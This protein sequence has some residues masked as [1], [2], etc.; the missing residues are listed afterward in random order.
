MNLVFT[1]TLTGIIRR[2]HF[3]PSRHICEER[4]CVFLFSK[5]MEKFSFFFYHTLLQGKPAY[6]LSAW[7]QPAKLKVYVRLSV[8]LSLCLSH[9]PSI[10]KS[11]IEFVHELECKSVG[12]SLKAR[13]ICMACYI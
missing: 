9:F 4:A 7:F 13:K 1:L 12:F 11:K 3:L 8:R 2:A 6:G 10:L 5:A